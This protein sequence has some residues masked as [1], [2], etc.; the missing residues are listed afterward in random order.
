MPCAAAQPAEKRNDGGKTQ[1]FNDCVAV[2]RH[3]PPLTTTDQRRQR[4]RQPARRMASAA[5]R[6]DSAAPSIFA[7][8]KASPANTRV[9]PGIGSTGR[10][11]P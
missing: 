8:P 6:A 5:A 11:A 7:A 2:F 4:M 3:R 9:V 10:Q 1:R